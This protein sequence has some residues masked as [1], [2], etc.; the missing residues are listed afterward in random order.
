MRESELVEQAQDHPQWHA[1]VLAVL[2]IPLVNIT[3][4]L[5][6]LLKLIYANNRNCI[7]L[8]QDKEVLC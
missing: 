5:V 4:S 2:N 3:I 8:I 7:K 1:L 6:I